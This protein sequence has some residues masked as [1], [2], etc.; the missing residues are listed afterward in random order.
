MD[1]RVEVSGDV[2][3][4]AGKVTDHLFDAAA[5]LL[6][7]ACNHGHATRCSV[8]VEVKM[9]RVRLR[10]SDNGSGF[11]PEEALERSRQQTGLGLY[12]IMMIARSFGGDMQIGSAPKRGSVVDVVFAESASRRGG[13]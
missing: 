13:P 3:R 12:W 10:V 6:W 4:V 7:N 11:V 1:V 9:G 5:E 8:L 2:S